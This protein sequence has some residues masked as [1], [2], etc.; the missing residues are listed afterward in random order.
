MWSTYDDRSPSFRFR[1]GIIDYGYSTILGG[2]LSAGFTWVQNHAHNGVVNDWVKNNQVRRPGQT[3][4][5]AEA[6]RIDVGKPSNPS[7][8]INAFSAKSNTTA[9][10]AWPWHSSGGCNVLWVDGH[11]TT[12]HASNANDPYTIYNTLGKIYS[13]GP[14]PAYPCYWLIK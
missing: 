12:E 13:D 3:I 5:V 1:Y 6:A 11:V 4:M 14:D 10:V 2:G 7:H 9:Y 8:Y